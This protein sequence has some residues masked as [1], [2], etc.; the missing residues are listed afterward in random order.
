MMAWEKSD[1]YI[2]IISRYSHSKKLLYVREKVKFN[3]N[4]NG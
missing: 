4:A 1:Y 2:R 3:P